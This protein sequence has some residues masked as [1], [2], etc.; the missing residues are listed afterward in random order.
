MT[1]FSHKP[2]IKYDDAQNIIA[3][4]VENKRLKIKRSE[5][6]INKYRGDVTPKPKLQLIYEF[7]KAKSLNPFSL[8]AEHY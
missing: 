7:P 1:F 8:S 5:E 6:G 3:P 4:V 2:L